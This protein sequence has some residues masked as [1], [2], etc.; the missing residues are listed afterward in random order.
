MRFI[1][2][3]AFIGCASP[4][5]LEEGE[6]SHEAICLTCEEEGGGGLIPPPVDLL[7]VDQTWTEST[8]QDVLSES[9]AVIEGTD[10]PALDQ[11][12]ADETGL[13]GWNV[14]VSTALVED[15]LSSLSLVPAPKCSNSGWIGCRVRWGSGPSTSLTWTCW[16]HTPLGSAY[17]DG[18]GSFDRV[19]DPTGGFKKR[20]RPRSLIGRCGK[21]A[22]RC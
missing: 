12:I 9:D 18:T 10:G 16:V 7:S 11:A 22:L 1:A 13:L 21:G 20:I 19:D 8:T 17:C 2:F 6:A 15:E 14:G 3:L 5:P 4:V